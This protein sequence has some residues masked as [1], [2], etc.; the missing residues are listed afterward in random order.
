MDLSRLFNFDGFV[1]SRG[2]A[3]DFYAKFVRTQMF[4]KFIGD[5]SGVPNE[6]FINKILPINLKNRVTPYLGVRRHSIVTSAAH[7]LYVLRFVLRKG[8]VAVI[9]NIL[10]DTTIADRGGRRGVCALTRQ[11][12]HIRASKPHDFRHAARP[13]ENRRRRHAAAPCV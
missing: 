6:V 2:S 10:C 7:L 13:A 11:R 12:V 5:R 1:R 8:A 4:E 3:H 9:T